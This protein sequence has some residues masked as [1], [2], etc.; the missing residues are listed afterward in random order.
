VNSKGNNLVLELCFVFEVRHTLWRHSTSVSSH[1]EQ[2]PG[3]RTVHM[4]NICLYVQ[5]CEVSRR[6]LA[7]NLEHVTSARDRLLS[8]IQQNLAS[9]FQGSM[10]L[11]LKVNGP[12]EAERRLPSTLR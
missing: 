11:A 12:V 8:K 4:S 10:R 9:G 7:R 2:K 3:S 1:Q 6:D 5:A